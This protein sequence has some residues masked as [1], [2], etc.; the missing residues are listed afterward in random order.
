MLI[1]N[2]DED[3][4]IHKDKTIATVSESLFTHLPRQHCAVFLAVHTWYS[5]DPTLNLQAFLYNQKRI[6]QWKITFNNPL[7]N[8]VSN[9][10][11]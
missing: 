11:T 3:L 1:P 4:T 10:I 8:F 5:A 9:K 6:M 2:L 7:N